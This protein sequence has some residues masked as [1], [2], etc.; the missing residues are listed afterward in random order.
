M[1]KIYKKPLITV[2]ELTLDQ[3]IAANCNANRYIL[4]SMVE[5]GCFMSGEDKCKDYPLY[6]GP[7]GVGLWEDENGDGSPDYENGFY[8]SLCYH[9]NVITAFY[10]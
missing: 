10:S 4:E 8:N 5:M 9:S 3:P 7:Y 1:K 2:E 6:T